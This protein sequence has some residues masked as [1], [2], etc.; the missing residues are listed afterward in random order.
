[1]QNHSHDFGWEVAGMPTLFCDCGEKIEGDEISRRLSAQMEIGE[2]ALNTFGDGQRNTGLMNH[3]L[4]EIAEL[5]E[6]VASGGD[7]SEEAADCLMLLFDLAHRN[8]FDLLEETLLKL[9]INKAR[10][11]GEIDENGVVEHKK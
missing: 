6:R 7:L 2:W 4:K 3:L 10:E 1:M 5:D 11:W 8:D 9:D